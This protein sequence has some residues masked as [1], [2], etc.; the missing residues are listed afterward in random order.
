M[1]APDS[2]PDSTWRWPLPD[3][4]WKEH[5]SAAAVSGS[6]LY[7][8]VLELADETAEPVTRG[9]VLTHFGDAL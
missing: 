3:Y 6:E 8:R 4:D 1:S 5:Q 2:E 9:W 7:D